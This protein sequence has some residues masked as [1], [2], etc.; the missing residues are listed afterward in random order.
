[1]LNCHIVLKAER[2]ISFGLNSA[3]YLGNEYVINEIIVFCSVLSK[4]FKFLKVN[5][6]TCSKKKKTLHPYCFVQVSLLFFDL[7]SKEGKW[8][9]LLT[10]VH[11][12]LFY[13]TTYIIM[14]SWAYSSWFPMK[15]SC[16]LAFSRTLKFF[17][18]CTKDLNLTFFYTC[19]LWSFSSNVKHVFL[20]T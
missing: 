14:F 20:V 4:N 7:L 11:H 16:C 9:F 18:L 6:I 1:M 3:I 13:R 15:E 8:V 19:I 12:F 2:V 5:F 10:T 17:R